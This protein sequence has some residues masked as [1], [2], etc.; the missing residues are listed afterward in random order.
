VSR[1]L[2]QRLEGLQVERRA[3]ETELRN[4]AALS[5]EADVRARGELDVLQRNVARLRKSV[6]QLEVQLG[7]TKATPRDGQ[8]S[9]SSAMSVLAPL[10]LVLAMLLIAVGVAVT[11]WPRG[12]ALIAVAGGL[13]LMLLKPD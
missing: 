7:R 4:P 1:D 5:T 13:R 9:W 2:R 10:Y 3:L 12:I 11:D 8:K 6:A